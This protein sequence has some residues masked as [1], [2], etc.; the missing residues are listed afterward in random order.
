MIEQPSIPTRKGDDHM[1]TGDVYIDTVVQ[2]AEPSPVR[3]NAVHFTPGAR[4]AWHSHALGQYLH[5]VEGTALVQERD[6][7]VVA[8]RPGETVYTPPGVWH[9]HGATAEQ[10]MTHLAIWQAPETGDESKWGE[11]VTDEEYSERPRPLGS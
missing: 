5:V 9:W 7:E 3:V 6:G 4:T 10:L 8:V 11:H 1:F 2:S